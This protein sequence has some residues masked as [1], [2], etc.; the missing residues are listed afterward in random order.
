MRAGVPRAAIILE[1]TS[2]STEEQALNAHRMMAEH[3]WRSAILVSDSY[4]VFRAR[5]L[6]RRV[7]IDVVL[8]PVPAARIESPAF[9]VHSVLREVMA[10]HWQV[11]K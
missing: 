10:L 2:R 8:S 3:G 6:V 1:E 7:G 5:Y 9:Y 4:H 11:V